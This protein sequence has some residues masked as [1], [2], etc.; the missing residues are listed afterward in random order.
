MSEKRKACKVSVPVHYTNPATMEETHE[1][2]EMH[3]CPVCG[4]KAEFIRDHYGPMASGYEYWSCTNNYSNCY[5][6]EISG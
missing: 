6:N 5:W 4:N 2:I 3:F 1:V